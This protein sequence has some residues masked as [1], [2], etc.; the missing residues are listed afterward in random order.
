MGKDES[1]ASRCAVTRSCTSL[2]ADTS[3]AFKHSVA[4]EMPVNGAL[5]RTVAFEKV[6]SYSPRFRGSPYL[7]NTSTGP[8]GAAH[9]VG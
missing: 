5:N 4:K 2:S 1:T 3:R 9:S 8:S 6:C 7:K